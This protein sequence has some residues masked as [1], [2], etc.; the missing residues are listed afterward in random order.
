MIPVLRAR[1]VGLAL[2]LA[3][4]L[5]PVCAFGADATPPT[6]VAPTAAPLARWS[7]IK[8]DTYAQRSHFADGARLLL[9]RL[10][11]E[12][13]PLNAKRAGMITDTKDWD[14]AMKEV[15]NCRGL[16]VDR[17]GELAQAT[18]PEAWAHVKDEVDLAWHR[19]ILAIDKM[20]S[21]VTS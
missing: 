12:I 2:G 16:L 19:A 18:T 7:D 15:N 13:A 21:T 14:F 3:A 10:D 11:G 4:A 1:N 20:T 17:I 5:L 8:G 6:P 9:A